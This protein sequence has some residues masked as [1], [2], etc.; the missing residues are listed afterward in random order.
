[1]CRIS[2][3]MENLLELLLVILM[4]MHPLVLYNFLLNSTYFLVHLRTH[5]TLGRG[6]PASR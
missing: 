2:H 4:L 5:P 1:M 3:I 6:F